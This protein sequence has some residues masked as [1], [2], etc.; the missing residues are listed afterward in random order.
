ML[1]Y[2][3]I[4]FVLAMAIAPLTHFLPS[5]RQ[6]QLARMREYAAVHGLFVE[7]R[8]LPQA[9]DAAGRAGK[10]QQSIYYGKRLRPSR[11]EPRQRRAWLREEGGWRGLHRRW[12]PPAIAEAM[13]ASVLA[14]G[15]DEGSCGIYWQE[16][17]EEADVELIV[18]A[19]KG[20]EVVLSGAEKP[21]L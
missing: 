12:T 10:T 7:F 2:L 1:K 6:R 17:G 16:A 18:E 5:K 21:R 14:L 13:P 3:I 15:V 20:W 11:A 19:L 9:D 4:L 8:D